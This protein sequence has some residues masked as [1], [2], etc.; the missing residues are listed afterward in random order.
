MGPRGLAHLYWYRP[1][2]LMLFRITPGPKEFDSDELQFFMKNYVDDLIRLYEHGINVKTPNFPEASCKVC[3]FGGHCKEDSFC[4][5]CHIKRSELQTK[6]AMSYDIYICSLRCQAWWDD[7]LKQVGYPAGG[8]LTSD[9]WKGLALIFC[10]IM[11]PFI[12]DKWCPKNAATY[13]KTL[14]SWETQERQWLLHMAALKIIL[15]RSIQDSDIPRAKQL[16]NNYLLEYLELYPDD[17]MKP[18][19]HWVTHIFDQLHDYGPIYNFW[20]FLFEQL[21]KV[22]RSYSTNNHGGGKIELSALSTQ[23]SDK[24]YQP[25]TSSFWML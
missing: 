7:Y 2:N 12:W 10:P 5:C 11:I 20:T 4:T 19:H 25:K 1:C 18:T 14:T 6:D 9:E 15:G 22:L 21:N 3:G 16:L 24:D 8:S 17:D 13:E 23:S